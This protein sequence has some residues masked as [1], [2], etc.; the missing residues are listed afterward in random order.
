[1]IIAAN[2]LFGINLEKG[3]KKAVIP[4]L[5]IL[6]HT[7]PLHTKT[8]G[9]KDIDPNYIMCRKLLTNVT[10]IGEFMGMLYAIDGIKR[11]IPLQMELFA[12]PRS[13]LSKY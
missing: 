6:E 2:V 5:E 4:K 13:I 12:V 1:L 8:L 10:S 3:S 9:E 11:V 7:N